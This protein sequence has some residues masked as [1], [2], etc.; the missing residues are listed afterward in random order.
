MDWRQFSE[1]KLQDILP[2]AEIIPP[3]DQFIFSFG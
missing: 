3:V 2:T 1:I